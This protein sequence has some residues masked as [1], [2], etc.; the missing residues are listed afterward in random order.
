M[1][2]TDISLVVGKRIRDRRKKLKLSQTDLALD[3]G[4][5]KSSI[6]RLEQ[7]KTDIMLR[8]LD[9]IA[10]ELGTTVSKLTEP[11]RDNSKTNVG[12]L[13][14]FLQENAEWI[15]SLPPETIEKTKKHMTLALDLPI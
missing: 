15:N 7:G 6:S 2:E 4:S 13:I 8:K 3:T 14:A 12:M 11:E 5:E 9:C 1:P 10:Y